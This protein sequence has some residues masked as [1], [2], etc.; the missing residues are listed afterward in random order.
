[1][2]PFQPGTAVKKQ[3]PKTDKSVFKRSS[4]FFSVNQN[5]F[6]TT[7]SANNIAFIQFLISLIL[8]R[9]LKSPLKNT[10]VVVWKRE[11]RQ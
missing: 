1:M 3:T 5:M 7:S 9:K 10:Q 11:G 6:P 8:L 2:N 4:K